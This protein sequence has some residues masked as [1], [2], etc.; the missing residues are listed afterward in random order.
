M[1]V[2][3]VGASGYATKGVEIDLTTDACGVQHIEPD[4]PRDRL[5]GFGNVVSVGMMPLE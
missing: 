1:H 5:P 3:A 4:G 2:A